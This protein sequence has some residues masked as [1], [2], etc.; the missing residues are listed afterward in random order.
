MEILKKGENSDNIKMY[1]QLYINFFYSVF[2]NN[3]K[4][5]YEIEFKK[6]LKEAKEY[7]NLNRYFIK[8]KEEIKNELDKINNSTNN[9]KLI[10]K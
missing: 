3:K 10:K 9:K 2:I 4:I 1:M 6:K 8:H 5:P 7:F